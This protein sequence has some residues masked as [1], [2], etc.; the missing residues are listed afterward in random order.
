MSI[1]TLARPDNAN[2]L[3]AELAA[4][5]LGA[6][7][8]VAVD[9]TRAA[10]ITG[11]GSAFSAG[12]DFRTIQDMQDPEIR[13]AVLDVHR[14][15][16]WQLVRSPIPTVAAVNG[17]AVGAGVTLAVLADL[18]VMSQDAY[19]SDPRV[20]LGLLDG[21][22]GLIIWPLLTSLSA[23]REYLLLGDRLNA[24]DAYRLGVVNRVEPT[25]QVVP[26]A[27]ELARRLAALPAQATQQA[28]RLLNSQLELAAAGLLDACSTAETT[29][30]DSDEHRERLAELI[31]RTAA[32][33]ERTTP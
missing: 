22:G 21:A 2:A 33:N 25:E 23:A 1:V 3:D 16:F 13:T 28:R 11:E 20:S 12:G 26:A 32:R 14:E 4:A 18:V 27:V 17:P 15:L 6:V 19:L 31:A 30:F 10:V 9:G 8:R 29:C 5:L 24:G 7:Q